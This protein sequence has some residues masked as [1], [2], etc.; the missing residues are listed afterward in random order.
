MYKI[1]F[2][3]STP[4]NNRLCGISALLIVLMILQSSCS[5]QI[6]LQR[7]LARH[8]ELSTIDS[9]HIKDTVIIP[10]MKLDTSVIFSTKFD[11]IVLQKDKFHLVVKKIHDTL[12]IHAEVKR[13]TVYISKVLPVSKIKVIKETFLTTF[14]SIL[15]WL[16]IALITLTILAVFLHTWFKK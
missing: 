8:P 3:R 11:S 14:R 2:F 10:G 16:V 9:I 7:L 15:P 1:Q 12:V 5:P 6:R 4:Q 13:D